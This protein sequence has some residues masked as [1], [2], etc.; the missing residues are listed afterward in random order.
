MASYA[1]PRTIKITPQG[2]SHTFDLMTSLPVTSL[3]VTSHPVAML[4]SIM[5]NGTFFTT[6]IVE[7]KVG[8][9]FR[10]CAEHTSGNDVTSD[11]VI[12]FQSG[13][14]PVT[15]LPATHA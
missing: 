5:S 4:L 10:A 1:T 13:P 15:S 8:M 9:H 12:S 7:T 11:N 2:E 14:L 3:S 6:T